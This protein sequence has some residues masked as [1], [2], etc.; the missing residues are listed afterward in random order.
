VE[1]MLDFSFAHVGINQSDEFEAAETADELSEYFGFAQRDTSASCFA[2]SNLEIMKGKGTG[3]NGHI[4]I[5]TN[6]LFRAVAYLRR[7][8][9]E[10]RTDT[11]KYDEKG[12]I[13]FIYLA[14]EIGG[15]AVHLM[16]K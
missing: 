9:V 11:A 13:K 2:G 1:Q 8:G 16:Q 7:K 6:Y 14:D 10:F 5:K 12:R 4:G 3:T 15:F